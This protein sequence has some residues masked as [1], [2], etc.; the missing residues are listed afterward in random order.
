[1][2]IVT[3]RSRKEVIVLGQAFNLDGE[4]LKDATK[5]QIVETGQTMNVKNEFLQA[6]GDTHYALIPKS[7]TAIIG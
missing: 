3:V 6:E 1:M 5:I 7:M 2:L 4:P